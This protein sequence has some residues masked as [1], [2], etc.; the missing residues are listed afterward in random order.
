MTGSTL[1]T[2]VSRPHIE[3]RVRTGADAPWKYDSAN[4]AVLLGYEK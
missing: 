2:V 1:Q 3:V 4:P